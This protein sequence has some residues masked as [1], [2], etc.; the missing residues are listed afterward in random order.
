MTNP[1]T[2]PQTALLQ[3]LIIETRTNLAFAVFSP[4]EAALLDDVQF[5]VE[6]VFTG[7]RFVRT[8]L[9]K[10]LR[11]MQDKGLVNHGDPACADWYVYPLNW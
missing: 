9:Q 3:R 6:N 10:T 4:E 7:R 2:S 8:G 5:V 1:T 11:F